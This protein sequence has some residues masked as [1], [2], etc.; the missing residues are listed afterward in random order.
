MLGKTQLNVKG[1][2]S[3]HGVSSCILYRFQS[4]NYISIL[5]QQNGPYN[6]GGMCLLRSM[7]TCLNEVRIDICL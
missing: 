1:L 6:A 4:R 5:H 3:A 2:H 7:T